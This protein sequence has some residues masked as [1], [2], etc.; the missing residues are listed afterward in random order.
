MANKFHIIA[1]S[2]QSNTVDPII[3]YPTFTDIGATL[4]PDGG[5]AKSTWSVGAEVLNSTTNIPLND[6][7]YT[8]NDGYGHIASFEVISG[9]IVSLGTPC[10]TVQSVYAD[11]EN[12]FINNVDSNYYLN[13]NTEVY[14]ESQFGLDNE[15]L[16]GVYSFYPYEYTF[17]EGLLV[18]DPERICP[19]KYPYY[20]NCE[21][22]SIGSPQLG[23]VYTNTPVGDFEISTTI[24]YTDAEL[25]TFAEFLDIYIYAGGDSYYLSISAAG[26]LS[27]FQECVYGTAYSVYST[28]QDYNEAIGEYD[29]FLSPSDTFTIG[30]YV[31]TNAFL[32]SPASDFIYNGLHYVLTDGEITSIEDYEVASF[33]ELYS[34]CYN[35]DY[36]AILYFRSDGML[37][38]ND[39]VWTSMGGLTPD[40][41]TVLSYGTFVH[42]FK[43]INTNGLGRVIE[44]IPCSS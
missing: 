18:G 23:S 42:D 4:I 3:S 10:D 28:F 11:C 31:Y 35:T 14:Y 38:I 44:L 21:D 33:S 20:T 32:S 12:Y 24:F 29:V 41:W 40:D 34:D 30:T 13:S 7:K 16:D 22:A 5:Y 26:I 9:N 37:E 36:G 39:K 27:D 1:S 2:G 17:D 6:G 25:T 43:L 8:Y 15:K 19:Y